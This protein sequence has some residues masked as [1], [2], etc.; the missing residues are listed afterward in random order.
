MCAVIP[1]LMIA[2]MV[3]TAAST[4]ASMDEQ[5]KSSNRQADAIKEGLEK[6]QIQTRQ[7]QEQNNEALMEAQSQRHAEYLAER[8]RLQV[9]GAE[10]GLQGATDRSM[11]LTKTAED[12]D[13]ATLQ[14]NTLKANEQAR[15]SGTAKES[16]A[17]MQMAGLRRPSALGAGLQIA[18]QGASM[19][20]SYYKPQ[21][22]PAKT[23]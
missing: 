17:N 20:A 7:V 16:Q 9:V 5:R 13:I 8:G 6:E 19:A 3:L 14:A 18:A 12:Y 15:A 1:A 11:D 10:S 22:S 2:S 23:A 21:T 4:A